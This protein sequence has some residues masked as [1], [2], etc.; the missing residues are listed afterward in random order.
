M[1]P[2]ERLRVQGREHIVGIVMLQI[3]SADDLPRLANCELLSL[4]SRS[5]LI[6]FQ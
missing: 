4:L 5:F 2:Q 1:G 3:Q 6:S